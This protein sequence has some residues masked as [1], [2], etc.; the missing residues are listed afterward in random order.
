MT[1]RLTED[2]RSSHDVFERVVEEDEFR[3]LQITNP[4]M[5]VYIQFSITQLCQ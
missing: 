1:A 3:R 2:A 4:C 5:Y